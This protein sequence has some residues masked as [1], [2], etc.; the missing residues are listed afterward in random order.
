[1]PG[2]LPRGRVGFTPSSFPR[3]LKT[4]AETG[5]QLL[6]LFVFFVVFHSLNSDVLYIE[7]NRETVVMNGAVRLTFG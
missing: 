3:V 2:G 6:F 5:I 4:S 1:M 7:R